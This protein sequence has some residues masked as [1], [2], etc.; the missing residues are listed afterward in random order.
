MDGGHHAAGHLARRSGGRRRA[1][2]G[3]AFTFHSEPGA[4]FTCT[5]DGASRPCASPVSYTGLAEDRTC[6]P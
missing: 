5:L 4:R 6:S 3:I 2:E 1:D